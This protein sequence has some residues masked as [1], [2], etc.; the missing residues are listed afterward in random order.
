[1]EPFSVGKESGTAFGRCL[2]FEVALFHV[3]VANDLVVDAFHV[4]A[5]K[6]VEAACDFADGHRSVFGGVFAQLFS[7]QVEFFLCT[8]FG[9]YS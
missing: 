2:E 5:Y 9:A 3:P 7:G 6:S 1:M 4:V 8:R